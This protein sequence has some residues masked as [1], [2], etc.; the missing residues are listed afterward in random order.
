M[1]VRH[2]WVELSADIQSSWRESKGE[3]CSNDTAEKLCDEEKDA[4]D[5]G[6]GADEDHSYGNGWVYWLLAL[7]L[8]LG[9]HC[10][11]TH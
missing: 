6:D 2:R 8:I 7:F 4:T 5:R 9:V 10:W 11:S 1:C 3:S